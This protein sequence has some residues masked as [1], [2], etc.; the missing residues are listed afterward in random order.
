MALTIQTST[1]KI[2]VLVKHLA[3]D[4]LLSR[5]RGHKVK[6]AKSK[7]LMLTKCGSPKEQM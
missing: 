6:T 7:I 2:Y 4:L 5:K 1:T 3:V